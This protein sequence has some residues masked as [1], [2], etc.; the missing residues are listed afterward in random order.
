MMRNHYGITNLEEGLLSTVLP[1][2]T[3]G[4]GPLVDPQRTLFLW[5]S[6]GTK[7][8]QG[9]TLSFFLSDNRLEPLW[10]RPSFYAL[11]FVRDGVLSLVE[12]DFSVWVDDPIETQLF[13]TK[14]K[15][16][17]AR[18]WQE[19]GLM[20]APNLNWSGPESFKFCF[21]G[22]PSHCP[23]A[24]TECRTCS[25]SAVDRRAFLCGLHEA[26]RQVRPRTLIIYGGAPNEWWIKRDLPAGDTQ[27]VFLESWT[28]SRT[29]VRKAQERQ[30]RERN[31]YQLFS[32]GG[33]Q[34]A[35]EAVQA[36]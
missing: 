27:F 7:A 4:G 9:G 5:R 2:R 22:V 25:S 23:V 32:T 30:E 12:P 11:Q 1:R 33:T 35:E 10:A 26:I 21:S 24:F 36:A 29:R 28:D 19:Y 17:V 34:W 15:R 14:R 16:I 6:C 3:H 8:A 18:Q 31:Q 20:I 13:N